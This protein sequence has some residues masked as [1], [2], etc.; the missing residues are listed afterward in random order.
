MSIQNLLID[1]FVEIIPIGMS[2][3]CSNYDLIGL[4][5]RFISDI[6]L[7]QIGFFPHILHFG[8]FVNLKYNLLFVDLWENSEMLLEISHV[9]KN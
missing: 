8:V 4:H 2:S 5:Y 9:L 1:L 7:S 3:I 6:I